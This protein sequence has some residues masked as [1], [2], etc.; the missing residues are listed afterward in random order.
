MHPPSSS[1]A[2]PGPTT[3]AFLVGSRFPGYVYD[4]APRNVYWETT[5]ACDLACQHCRANAIQ[6]RDP[7]ELTFEEG[8]ALL[9]EIKQLG[10][11]LNRRRR[12]SVSRPARAGAPTMP[13]KN[14][15]P[16]Q[17]MAARRW[18]VTEAR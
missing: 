13:R 18:R 3:K 14:M 9:E 5:I 4:R 17:K 2:H 7:L 16:I 11:S 1:W 12:R 10:S 6:D 8:K 15:P